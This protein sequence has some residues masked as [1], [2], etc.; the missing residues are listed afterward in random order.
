MFRWT[1]QPAFPLDRISGSSQEWQSWY[2]RELQMWAEEG[3]PERFDSLESW[4]LSAPWEEPV[5]AVEGSD[6]Q[7][8]LWDGTIASGSATPMRR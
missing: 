2:A 5:I 6:G 8:Y 4:E 3:T 7:F 1:Y